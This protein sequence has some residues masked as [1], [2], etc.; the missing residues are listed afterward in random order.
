[1]PAVTLQNSTVH[2]NQNCGVLTAFFAETLLAVIIFLVVIFAGSK[3]GG[4]QP[5]A[6]TR[7]LNTPSIITRK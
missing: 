6:G 5:G 7:T 4:F 2:S 3:F 1:M